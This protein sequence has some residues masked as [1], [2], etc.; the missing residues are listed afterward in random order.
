AIVVGWSLVNECVHLQL[1][2]VRKLP[3]YEILVSANTHAAWRGN[4]R[5]DN[6]AARLLRHLARHRGTRH[7]TV[8]PSTRHPGTQS[9]PTLRLIDASLVS[10][11]FG[12]RI[13]RGGDGIPDR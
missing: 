11:P 1:Q 13:G 10:D 8:A 9:P 5:A 3:R 2:L 7:G 12:S 4:A 6:L